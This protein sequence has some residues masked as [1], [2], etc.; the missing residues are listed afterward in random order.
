MMAPG[1]TAARGTKVPVVF[2]PITRTEYGIEHPVELAAADVG[3]QPAWLTAEGDDTRPVPVAQGALN[4]LDGSAHR[5]FGRF[6]GR[7]RRL[8]V[9]VDDDDHVDGP[10][11]Q[12]LGDVQGASA[13]TDGPVDRPQLITRHVAANT[14]VLDTPSHVPRHVRA[15]SI[16]QFGARQC[17]GLR[18]GDGEYEHLG[19]HRRIPRSSPREQTTPPDDVDPHRDWIPA[20]PLGGQLQFDP[21]RRGSDYLQHRT[22]RRADRQLDRRAVISRR[23]QLQPDRF[24]LEAAHHRRLRV[25][26]HAGRRTLPAQGHQR[27]EQRCG[28]EDQLPSRPDQRDRECHRRARGDR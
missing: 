1:G 15:E 27:P 8:V 24:S 4:H 14:A 19:R 21:P 18:W 2:V 11:A 12:S 25:H 22:C 5:A 9:G 17:G 6:G 28:E 7:S 26:L 20:P 16:Q 10:L 13:C 3:T 23:P